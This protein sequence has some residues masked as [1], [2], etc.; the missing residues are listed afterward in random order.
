M[1]T[2]IP[3]IALASTIAAACGSGPRNPDAFFAGFDAGAADAPF[4]DAFRPPVDAFAGTDTGTTVGMDAGTDAGSGPDGDAGNDAGGGAGRDAGGGPDARGPDAFM[5]PDTGVMPPANDTCATATMIGAGTLTGTTLGA[6]DDYGAGTMCAGTAGG[7]VVYAVEIPPGRVLVASVTSGDGSF[8]PSISLVDA[9]CGGSPRVCLDG[10]DSGGASTVNFVE[11]TNSTGAPERVLLVIDS[12]RAS[13]GGAFELSVALE[14]PS[15]NDTCASATPLASGADV[16]GSTRGTANDYTGGTNCFGTA[17]A[18][19]VY[20]LDVPA[21]QRATVSVEGADDFDPSINLVRGPAAS[22]GGSPFECLDGDDSFGTSTAVWTNET[23]ADTTVYA[24]VDSR[25]AT[26]SFRISANVALPGAGETCGTAQ[27]IMAGR[28][29]DSLTGYADDYG[30]GTG[31]AG[32]AGVDRVYVVSVGPGQ[33]LDADV[34][35]GDGSFD[36]SINLET[37]CG[38]TPRVCADG[39]DLGSATML[40]SVTFT[41][42]AAVPVDVFVVVETYLSSSTGGPFVMNVALTGP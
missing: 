42:G 37:S 8:D 31:C 14:V 36:P 41:N 28:Y 6:L 1:R 18:D 16:M 33:R 15:M 3:G 27:R 21:G 9:G 32:T 13:G 26:G 22:C 35:S 30:S 19:V 5:A 7:D 29:S 11:R 23:G 25:G 20:S 2:L 40:N 39:D 10:D 38:A 34:N 4:T 12:F 24:I 17:G